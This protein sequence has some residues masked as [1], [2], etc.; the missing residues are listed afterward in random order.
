ML[1]LPAELSAETGQKFAHHLSQELASR[2]QLAAM[3]SQRLEAVLAAAGT[4]SES[5]DLTLAKSIASGLLELVEN[6]SQ[7]KLPYVQAAVLYFQSVDDVNPDLESIAGFDD[8]AEVFN[9]VVHHLG[10]SDLEV[11]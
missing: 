11:I 6:E 9:A 4:D 5:V 1:D 2:Q 7:E 3:V 10:R 8:D